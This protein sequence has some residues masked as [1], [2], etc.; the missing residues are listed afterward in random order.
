[1]RLPI[2]H[3]YDAGLAFIGHEPFWRYSGN[4]MTL[5]DVEFVTYIVR[6]SYQET[7]QIV[8]SLKW[9]TLP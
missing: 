8:A 4:M 7:S 5:G 2:Q 1:M 9:L 3:M 6:T